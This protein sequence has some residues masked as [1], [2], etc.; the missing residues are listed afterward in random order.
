MRPDTA[1]ISGSPLMTSGW[2]CPSDL[3]STLGWTSSAR[4]SALRAG[5]QESDGRVH[6]D[7][8]PAA[9]LVSLAQVR[10][11]WPSSTTSS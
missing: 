4:P 1:D 5:Y 8:C 11:A 6:P 10:L 3:W 7:G 9:V 2:V